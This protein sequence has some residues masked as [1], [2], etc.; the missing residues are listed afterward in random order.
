[1][2]IT[3][4]GCGAAAGVPTVSQGWGRCDPANPK[5]RRRRASILVEEG[6]TTLLI[7]CSPDLRD[8]LLG[9]GV[10]RLDGVLIT[11]AHADHIHGLD[12]LREVNR[13]M[14]GPL[15]I[16]GTAETMQVLEDRFDYAFQGIP[17]GAEIFRPWLIPHVI[18]P[19]EE[20][21]LGAVTARVFIQDHGYSTSI[22]YRFADFAYSTDLRGLPPESMEVIRGA[23]LWIVGALQ[24]A[25]HK[26]HA[27]VEQVLAWAR[28][29]KPARTVITHMSTD[30]DYD[31]MIE[32]LLPVGITP[33]FDGMTIEV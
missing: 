15:P 13:A 3:I 19:G 16:Y 29:L 17:P 27:N 10:R 32:H 20:I 1:M 31:A 6:G 9:A 2:K 24:R 4:L 7:D 28:D 22:G 25:P 30:L 21:A 33:G 5:N 11:H 8:Q 18:A 26:T 23:K 12:E 14:G